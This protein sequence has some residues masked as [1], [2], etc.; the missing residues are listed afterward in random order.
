MIISYRLKELRLK[1]GFSQEQLGELIGVSKVA[2]CGYENGTKSPKMPRLIK[3]AEILDVEPK[4]LLGIEVNIIDEDYK[5]DNKI[6]SEIKND[7]R[8][9]HLLKTDFENTMKKIKNI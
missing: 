6:I 8:L 1:H 5:L 2:I 9:Y 3:L 7:K 4:Y